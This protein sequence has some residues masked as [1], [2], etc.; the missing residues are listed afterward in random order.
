MRTTTRQVV[1][2]VAAS[3]LGLGGLAVAAPA[4]AGA[5]LFGGPPAGAS[6]G[7][8][9]GDGTGMGMNGSGVN[10]GGNGPG[11]GSG[12]GSGA[13]DGACL[14]AAN[15]PEK[16]TLTEAQKGTLAAMAQEE[17]LAHD[18]YAAFAAKY[19]A[20]VFYRI[21]D[22]ETRHLTVVRTLLDRYGLA[23]PTSGQA[24]G[25]FSD[26]AVQA[27]YDRLLAQGQTSEAAALQVGQT[28]EQTDID[29]L[30]AAQE[31]LT[32]AD[33]RQVYERLLAAS[34]HHLT[35]FQR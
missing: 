11:T 7:H 12:M 17:K 25:Q 31:G 22:S 23:D 26:P 27:T 34:Q 21:A 35:A 19:D 30:R 2:V 33:V 14:D 8:G 16:G 15:L 20:V 29:D 3:A 9:W 4:V 6:A 5:G 24:A 32:A 18:L 13:R 28:V 10:R 1:V